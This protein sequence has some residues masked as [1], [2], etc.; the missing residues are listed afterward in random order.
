MT[1]RDRCRAA[2]RAIYHTY[3]HGGIT[4]IAAEMG[5][6]RDYLQHILAGRYR[7]EP[8]LGRVEE[9]LAQIAQPAAGTLLHRT[10]ET[11]HERL[12]PRSEVGEDIISHLRP[13][14]AQALSV[15]RR[16][17]SQNLLFCINAAI[18]KGRKCLSG[19]SAPL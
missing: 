5:V 12:S 8:L 17:L 15:P 2:K 9:R 14:L 1:Y 4:R 6:S 19:H 13:L 7:S 18:K 16:K 11:G 10:V 3:G